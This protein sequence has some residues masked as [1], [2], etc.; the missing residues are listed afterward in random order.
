MV[1]YTKNMIF[2]KNL[3]MLLP[4]YVMRYEK[5]AHL[6]SENP[7]M[8]QDLLSEYEEI[9]KH[10]ENELAGKGRSD[11]YTDLIGLIVRISDYIFKDE[12]V[13]RKGMGDIMGGKVL[14]LESERLRA[15]GKAIGEARG[16][17][18]GEA[19]GEARLSTLINKL[20][21]D[22]RSGEI[23]TVVSDSAKRQKL[24]KEYGI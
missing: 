7:E 2:E 3:L 21:L 23:Q 12:D 14:E 19:R 15:E 10:L 17:A 8:L 6:L 22:G 1:N 24:Y 4:F 18:I 5:D 11:L 20:I 13:V 9:C 16:E